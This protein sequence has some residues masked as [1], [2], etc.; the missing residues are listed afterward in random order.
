[1]EMGKRSILLYN[2]PSKMQWR[3]RQQMRK[4][5]V[6]DTNKIKGE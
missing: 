4:I 1:M 6:I 5:G 3:Q 2:L